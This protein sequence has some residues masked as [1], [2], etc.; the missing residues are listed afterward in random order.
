MGTN[1]YDKALWAF[2]SSSVRHRTKIHCANCAWLVQTF[3]PSIRHVSP[4]STAVVRTPAR[5]EPAPGSLKPWHQYSSPFKIGGK[6][7][8]CCSGE[9]KVIS[10]GPSKPSPKKPARCGPLAKVYSCANTNSSETDTSRPPKAL[11]QVSPNQ[12]ARP[13]SCSQATRTCQSCAPISAEVPSL[14]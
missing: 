2:S 1:K 11:G 12:P 8:C 6:K 14:R 7:R 13:S 5:S 9:P 4:S 3:W 10:V